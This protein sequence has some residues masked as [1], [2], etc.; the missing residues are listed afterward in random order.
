MS[1]IFNGIIQSWCN[2]L[3]HSDKADTP[4][5][6]KKQKRRTTNFLYQLKNTKAMKQ[7]ILL[8]IA[9][10][11]LALSSYSQDKL[12][13]YLLTGESYQEALENIG[14]MTIADKTL[15]LYALDGQMLYEQ[16]L[17]DVKKLTFK[18]D[19]SVEEIISGQPVQL[20]A[21]P[22]PTQD[23]I[24]ISGLKEGETVRIF[25]TDGQLLKT[26][27]AEGSEMQIEV[28]SYR[29]GIYILQAGINIIKFIKE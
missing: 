20:K 12:Y 25:S 23:A 10:L 8:L 13:V 5:A 6:G 17:K 1:Y 29:K 19:L 18:E 16:S 21:Y 3:I 15:R 7:K 11:C 26:F 22:N 27:T 14:S 2:P 9:G 28:S 4:A 24:T